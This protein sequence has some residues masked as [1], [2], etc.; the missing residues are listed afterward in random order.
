MI[1][2]MDA[3]ALYPS[4]KIYRSAEVVFE[5]LCETE[6]TLKN[7]DNVELQRYTAVVL[8]ERTL[9]KHALGMYVMRRKSKYG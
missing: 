1:F 3:K 4:I 9:T 8:D 5:L 7:I 2:S 6:V